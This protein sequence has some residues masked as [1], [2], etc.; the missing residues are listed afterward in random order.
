MNT[1]IPPAAHPTI[2]SV[3]V[4]RLITNQFPH[5]AGLPIKPV[6]SGGWDNR[7]FHL[8]P[9]MTV[10]LPSGK[11]YSPQVEKEQKWLPKLARHVPL[12]IP[13]P[14]ALG[15]PAEGYPWQWSVYQ[16]I[17]GENASGTN[18]ADLNSFAESLA[19]FLVALQ[20]IDPTNG[21]VPGRHNFFRG[22]SLSIYD[23]ETREAIVS[24][25]GRLDSDTTLLVWETALR[26]TWRGSPVWVHGDI[27]CDNLLVANGDLSAVIDFGC[28][29]V[30]D[31]AC[32]LVI[33]WTFL[34]GE[35]RGIFRHLVTVDSSTWARARGW[36]L[37]KALIALRAQRDKNSRQAEK[38]QQVIDEVLADYLSDSL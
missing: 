17:D 32:D 34:S 10:R 5:W 12:P 30:G 37:W 6:E 31:P 23:L 27:S 29:A 26:A 2:D 9:G 11:H 20:Q 19:C 18:I 21:P 38:A 33:A 36:A 3:L 8:G 1:D 22:D 4:T 35:S 24:L 28:C 7:T 14:L 15:E 16:W 25:A 13:T